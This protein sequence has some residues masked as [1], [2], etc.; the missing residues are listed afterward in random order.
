[1]KTHTEDT[2][3][4]LI[5]EHL[6]LHGGYEPRGRTTYEPDKAL[7]THAGY[8]VQ[9]ALIPAEV[10]AFVQATQP[11]PWAKLQAIHGAALDRIFLDALCKV[12]DQRGA[13]SVIR[14][15]FKFHGRQI[16]LA[17]FA[18]GHKLN[19][20]VWD[21]YGQNRLRVV[22]QLRYDPKNDNELDLVLFLNGLPIATAEL[23]NPMTGQKAD[24]AKRQ[25]KEH[26]DPKAPLFRFKARA[27]VHFAVDA[28]EVWMTT[29]LRGLSTRFLPFNRGYN[30][31]A[32]NPTVEGKH[33]TCYLWEEVWQRD[34]LLDLVGRFIHLQQE[35][36]TDP[37]T[38]K[39]TRTETMIFPRYHQ[40]DS[41]RRLIGAARLQGAGTNYLV[42]H[43]AGSGKSN[44]IAWL[45][46][47]LASL[48]DEADRKV[49]DAV[50]VVTDRKVLDQQLQETIY[51]FEHK[52]G[53][54]E[55]IDTNSAQ[56]AEALTAG[57]PIVISTIHKF[58]F[59]QDKIEHLPDRR[60]ALIVDEAHS[61]QSGEMAVT[62][63]ELLSD[64]GIAAKLAEEG[65]DLS[66]PDQLALR[67]A[68]FRG[69]QKNMS[70]FAFTATPKFKTLEL[71]GHKGPDGKPAPFHL[72]SMRQAIEEGFILDVLQGYT[73]YKRFF[74]LAKA[75]ADDPDLDKKKAASA[76]ARFVSLHPTNIAQKTEIVIEHFRSCVMHKLQGRAKA[77]LVTGS[78]LMAVKYRLA[79]DAYLRDKGYKGIRCLVAFSG[80]VQNDQVPGVGYTEPRMNLGL[81]E[82]ELP[83]AFASNIYQVLIV[84]N[85]YQTG[86]D[87]PLLCA[88]YVDKRLA[89]IQAVQTLSRLNRMA[90]GKEETF[91]LDFVNERD[92]IL[93]SFQDYYETTTTADEID[94]QRL[95]ELQHELEQFQVYTKAE[96]N[97]FSAAFFKM[98]GEQNLADSAQLNA[99]L[100][101]GVDRFK[102]LEDGDSDEEGEQRRE[103]FRGK[104]GAFKNLYGFLGQIVPFADADIE[105]LYA[106]GRMLLRKL[107]RPDSGG[108]IDLGDDVALAS[109]RLK[110][111][112]EGNLDLEGGGVGKLSGPE[113][114]GGGKPKPEHEK[115]SAIIDIINERFGT[116]F[117]AR[118]LVDG[119]TAQLVADE[120]LQQAAKVNDKGNFAVPFREALD[121]ALVN[122]HEKHGDFI[123][124][125]FQDEELGSFFRDWMLDRIYGRLNGPDGRVAET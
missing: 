1:M 98:K 107:P 96:V 91:V 11:K 19:P 43:S 89:G 20:A 45:A 78:R 47:R 117:D 42:Q 65:E 101:P 106:Y 68:L 30:N 112:A 46:H 71:F 119:V 111:E 75:I 90:L 13:L 110:L 21:L 24:R 38:G 103:E 3:E 116:D 122:R 113:Y 57:V 66:A 102:A 48:H 54:V 60:Y 29:R 120:D 83:R 77:M 125:L 88:M 17:Y 92:D 14:Q 124:K 94:P 69:P 81:K 73:T 28:D 56:L 95:Y 8:D 35:E 44:S 87:Q 5:V 105:K 76:L 123:N 109:F 52:T 100:D 55:K 12:M 32:G 86:F 39:T 2:F 40:M 53:V 79:F 108:P 31:G 93:A 49:Y 63:K 10:I 23:K 99:W 72:Y 9:R 85:K 97:G 80:E 70:F 41:V 33:R 16:R 115:L 84:A 62:V 25:Y 15:G 61:S 59:I 4:K 7:T 50:V 82:T 27:L 67:A 121:D 58:G 34:S 6:V 74:A 18:P 104:L 51:Q 114:T 37:N 118:D 22:R 64:S 26:R 36:M